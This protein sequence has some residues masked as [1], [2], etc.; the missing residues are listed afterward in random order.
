[1]MNF[2]SERLLLTLWVGALWAI[3]Y[4][5]V[6]IA[7]ATLGDVNLAGDYAGRLFHAVNILGIGV[8]LVLL[9][10][11]LIQLKTAMFGL[12]RVWLL[13]TMLTLTLVFLLYLQPEIAAIKALDWHADNSLVEQFNSLHKIS[14][15]V[16]HLLSLLGLA[17]VVSKDSAKGEL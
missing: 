11:K 4:L 3:G 7:F 14:E 12:W 2:I 1:M 5:A 17:L 13:L 6:P 15:Y 16:Y 9:I 8:C 10:T